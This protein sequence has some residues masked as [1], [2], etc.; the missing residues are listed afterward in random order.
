M[1]LKQLLYILTI[2]LSA[3]TLCASEKHTSEIIGQWKGSGVIILTHVDKAKFFGE[4]NAILSVKRA[5]NT[6]IDKLP[7][8]CM[9][10][11]KIDL[12][13][14]AVTA[15]GDCLIGVENN[16]IFAGFECSGSR[17]GC[18]GKMTFGGGTGRF[19]GISGSSRFHSRTEE[20]AFALAK[21]RVLAKKVSHGILTLTDLVYEIPG[22]K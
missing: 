18:T 1:N 7:I 5:D 20:G 4:I 17:G 8:V 15:Q 22:E 9:T 3:N 19:S 21:G 2:G 11:Q 16:V 10:T 6:T 14:A 13:N 12:T